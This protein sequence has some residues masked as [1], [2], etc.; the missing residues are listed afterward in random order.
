MESPYWQTAGQ[1]HHV[2]LGTLKLICFDL[3][4]LIEA[5]RAVVENFD[6][7]EAEEGRRLDTRTQPLIALHVELSDVQVRKH[8][9]QLA[10]LT[11][12]YDDLMRDSELSGAYRQHVLKYDG[13]DALGWISDGHFGVRQACNKIIHAREIRPTYDRLD[14][15]VIEGFED[16]ETLIFLTGE[17]ELNGRHNA[18]NWEGA[19]YIQPFI[20]TVLE[21][22]SFSL[23]NM[24]SATVKIS[25]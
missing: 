15:T 7:M 4:N 12:T 17:V 25:K 24:E 23:S 18:T 9:L 21:R 20:E 10:L 14:R 19:I 6:A 8:L 16:E 1:G 13:G 5:S 3:L 11:R 2:D 22:I